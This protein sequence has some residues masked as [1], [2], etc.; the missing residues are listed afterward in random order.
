MTTTP[1]DPPVTAAAAVQRLWHHAGLPAEALRH[2]HLAGAEPALPSSFAVG[3]ALQSA[4]AAAGL[5]AA[6]LRGAARRRLAGVRQWLDG[7][8]RVPDGI[9]GAWPPFDDAAMDE[10]DSGWGRL[11][12]VRHAVAF[13]GVRAGWTRPSVR[14]G[15]DEPV[16]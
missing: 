3:T 5:A 14:P 9:H 13:D 1:H 8:G 10:T 2:L 11:R 4:A 16:W 7:L 15:A 12:A 6:S